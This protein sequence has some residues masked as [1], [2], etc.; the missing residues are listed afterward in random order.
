MN[1]GAARLRPM[2]GNRARALIAPDTLRITRQH[3]ITAPRPCRTAIAALAGRTAPRLTLLVMQATPARTKHRLSAPATATRRFLHGVGSLAW[4]KWACRRPS[5]LFQLTKWSEILS[6]MVKIGSRFGI[7]WDAAPR[8][9]LHF[10][11]SEA[12]F[13]RD[14]GV[15]K[16][17]TYF[18]NVTGRAGAWERCVTGERQRSDPTPSYLR[19]LLARGL[20]S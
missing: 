5:R 10:R 14:G 16:G 20:S 2:V 17:G 15:A 12:L 13:G 18:Q 9:D 6:G 1:N 4:E 11:R 3:R 7:C 8:A 19:L